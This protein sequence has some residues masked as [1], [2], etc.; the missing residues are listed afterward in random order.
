MKKGKSQQRKVVVDFPKG[1]CLEG[2]TGFF[3]S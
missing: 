3:G 1:T 2:Y